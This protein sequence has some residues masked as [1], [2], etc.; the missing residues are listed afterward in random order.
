MKNSLLCGA[1]WIDPVEFAFSSRRTIEFALDQDQTNFR[2]L[3]DAWLE[4]G[5]L[6]DTDDL[7]VFGK[8]HEIISAKL[9]DQ[10]VH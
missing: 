6:A 1:R 9:R 5:I 2:S 10:N 4:S 8:L 3:N 7:K